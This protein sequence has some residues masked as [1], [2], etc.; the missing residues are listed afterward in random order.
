MV[1]TSGRS[2]AHVNAYDALNAIEECTAPAAAHLGSAMGG[3]MTQNT[4][5]N[6]S[7]L[8]EEYQ[9]RG[10]EGLATFLFGSDWYTIPLEGEDEERQRKANASIGGGKDGNKI[11]SINNGAKKVTGG[12]TLL[13][14]MPS[15][16]TNTTVNTTALTK[17]KQLPNLGGERNVS[18]S[19]DRSNAGNGAVDNSS[20]NIGSGRW[21]APYLGSLAPFPLVTRADNIANPHRLQG[22]SAV[23]SL[24][25]LAMEVEACR[26]NGLGINDKMGLGPLTKRPRKGNIVNSESDKS[27]KTLP[28][29]DKV[30]GENTN[31]AYGII[32]A[33]Q[34]ALRASLL[35]P[36]DVYSSSETLWGCIYEKDDPLAK[37]KDAVGDG[38][39]TATSGASKIVVGDNSK[40]SP[41]VTF[42][43]SAKAPPI[44][45]NSLKFL[46]GEQ[47]QGAPP[48]PTI[49]MPS[50]V[51]N[52]LPPFPTEYSS[53]LGADG[54]SSAIASSAIMGEVLSRVSYRRDKRKLRLGEL[55]NASS[56]LRP[57]EGKEAV[58][59][60]SGRDSVR[61]SVIGLGKSAGPSYWGSDWLGNDDK[62]MGKKDGTLSSNLPSVTVTTGVL[63]GS[64]LLTAN[65]V[66]KEV[67]GSSASR[68]S[69]LDASQVVPLGRASGSRVSKILEGSMNL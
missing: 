46:N 65:A 6:D 33:A 24:H 62:S 18:F 37:N 26:E 45:D 51:P 11:S 48:A 49:I 69:G 61:R 10:W 23:L 39:K 57:I 54:M 68:K 32:D 12:K 53:E 34:S 63:A 16:T 9:G 29:I 17:G 58:A 47:E 42:D 5:C 27:K 59:A 64:E 40:S 20:G 41:K 2:S 35:I 15:T 4:N 52:F 30:N 7:T 28:T 50:Y 38:G 25:D 19:I 55:N 66:M 60:T 44:D 56:S 67:V 21:D 14:K 1:E 43:A 22:T 31:N 3:V 36:D 8:S 13:P